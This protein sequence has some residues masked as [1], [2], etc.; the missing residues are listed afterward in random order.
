MKVAMALA[1]LLPIGVAG[2]ADA[3]DPNSPEM[4]GLL[5]SPLAFTE[6][7][8]EVFDPNSD[9]NKEM[10][11]IPA[12]RPMKQDEE[13]ASAMAGVTGVA[14]AAVVRGV[15]ETVAM[16][17]DFRT[18]DGQ[19]V[20]LPTMTIAEVTREAQNLAKEQ[21]EL[22]A[23]RQNTTALILYIAKEKGSCG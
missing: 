14:C 3:P 18:P 8:G 22:V 19:R 17:K 1:L 13:F 12:N 7:C 23:G 15:F 4:L 5:D 20:C 21:P 11:K 2:A 10:A 9:I 16:A 6:V